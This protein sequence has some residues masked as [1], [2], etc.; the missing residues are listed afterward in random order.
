[1]ATKVGI[2]NDALSHLGQPPM[3]GPSDGSTW[4][5]RLNN[6]YPDT[7]RLLLEQHPWNFASKLVQL[8]RLPTATGGYAYSYNKPAD[9]LRINFINN[10]GDPEDNDWHEYEDADGKIHSDYDEVWMFFVSSTYLTKEGSFPQTFAR[11]LASELAFLCS[12]IATR[13]Q[14][15]SNGLFSVATRDLKRA[16]SFDASQKPFRRLPV[17]RWALSR[18][19]GVKYN[20]DGN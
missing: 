14:T 18:R 6:R 20:T 13:S 7:L 16:K 11:A 10:T 5:T 15:K 1:M 3:A 9:C 19:G 17:G 8:E 2:L 12:P 4:V